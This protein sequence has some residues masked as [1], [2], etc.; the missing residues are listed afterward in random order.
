[1]TPVPTLLT[2]RLVMRAL[3]PRD[4]PEAVAFYG[5]ERARFVGGPLDEGEA[6][7]KLA[8]Y[9]GHWRLR[10]D[11]GWLLEERE[12][13]RAVG[14]A[15]VVAWPEKP[16]PEIGWMAYE[17]GEGRGLIAEAVRAALAFVRDDLGWTR[18]VSFIAPGNRRSIALAER[19]GAVN[20]GNSPDFTALHD[21]PHDCWAHDLSEGEAAERGEPVALV[22]VPSI[23]TERLCLRA[24]EQRDHP[25]LAAFMASEGSR[26]IGGPSDEHATWR[27]MA[28]ML[29][30]WDLRGHGAWAIA[31][32]ESGELLGFALAWS[33]PPWPEREI[34]W[35]LLPE[36]RAQGYATE[37]GRAAR[38]FAYGADGWDTAVSYIHPDND[39]SKRVAKRLGAAREAVIEL[40]G[41]PAEVWRHPDP[42]SVSAETLH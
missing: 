16:E 34:G 5:T 33:P 9:L 7:R 37:A 27:M 22:E 28:T 13:G 32:R 17:A 8:A 39:A 41:S 21:E 4:V 3:A 12:S 20:E 36:A 29:G 25:A 40:K 11:G 1:M 35:T 19:V 18:A 10:G 24:F 14:F 23:E 26:W 6:W 15:G 30:H 31:G 38:A 42:S 2:E